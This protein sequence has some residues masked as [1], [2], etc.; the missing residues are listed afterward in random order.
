MSRSGRAVFEWCGGL[1]LALGLASACATQRAPRSPGQ[2][3]EIVRLERSYINSYLILGD[4]VI[5]VDT[6][7]PGNAKRVLKALKRRGYA[8]QDVALIVLTHGHADHA[9]AAAEL[10]ERTGA[11]IVAGAGD[12][13]M[14]G[15]GRND[16][17]VPTGKPGERILPFIGQDFPAFTPDTLVRESF[18]LHPLGVRGRV[19]AMPG[20]TPGSLVVVLDDGRAISGDLV[21]GKILK[22]S[23]P[24]LHFFHADVAAAEG[25]IATLLDKYGV[26]RFHPG[27]GHALEEP[28]LREYLR[29]RGVAAGR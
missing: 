16:R 19:L 10:R 28:A 1:A 11:A 22:R 26:R 6:G 14:L 13:P 3:I 20:H 5:V 15:R 9:G 23:R 8:A 18:D 12:A 25:N 24:V 7:V 21:R 29:D 17:L 2:P 27:H 4:R